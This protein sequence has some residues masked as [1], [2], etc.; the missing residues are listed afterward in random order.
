M[1]RIPQRELRNDSGRVLAAVA[2]GESIEVTSNGTVMAVMVPPNVS[3][4]E[5]GRRDGT[6]RPA[7]RRIRLSDVPR[8]RAAESIADVLDDLRGER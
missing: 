4:V 1:R 5:R 8:V 2:A 7:R 3:P 6:V